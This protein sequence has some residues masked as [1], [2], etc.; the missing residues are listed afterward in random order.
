MEQNQGD[1]FDIVELYEGRSTVVGKIHRHARL[2]VGG[3]I[4]WPHEI[5][6]PQQCPSKPST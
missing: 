2:A 6:E 1:T 3:K 5:K 4:V